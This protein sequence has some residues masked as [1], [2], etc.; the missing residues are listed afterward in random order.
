MLCASFFAAALKKLCPACFLLNHSRSVHLAARS[1]RTG[2]SEKTYLQLVNL[3]ERAY[4]E[5]LKAE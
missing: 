5:S 4:E 3:E 2:M 1:K